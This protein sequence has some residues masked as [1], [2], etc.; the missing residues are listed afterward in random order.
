MKVGVKRVLR[1]IVVG[2]LL[3]GLGGF[4]VAFAIRPSE[5]LVEIGGVVVVGALFGG[6]AAG[7][8]IVLARGVAS[9]SEAAKTK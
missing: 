8:T 6:F 4:A 5:P 2:T 7:Y 3:G 1:R 9:N